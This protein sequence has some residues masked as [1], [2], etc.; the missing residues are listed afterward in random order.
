[1]ARSPSPQIP[2]RRERKDQRQE[3]ALKYLKPIRNPLVSEPSMSR[4]QQTGPLCGSWKYED[5]V[6]IPPGCRNP[7]A[8]PRLTGAHAVIRLDERGPRVFREKRRERTR[9]VSERGR[10]QR[11]QSSITLL[12]GRRIPYRLLMG[13][14]APHC[15]RKGKA[16]Q[17][18]SAFATRLSS[19]AGEVG[20]RSRALEAYLGC[21]AWTLVP[22]SSGYPVR[23]TD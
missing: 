17:V 21:R 3:A 22:L 1:M 19:L 2:K 23:D 14:I 6:E 13:C 7:Q 18:G 11:F 15:I 5:L 8:T 20:P 16:G 4:K 12:L 9:P 10:L